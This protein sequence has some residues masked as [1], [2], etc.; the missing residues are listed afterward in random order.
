MER[1]TLM[2]DLSSSAAVKFQPVCVDAMAEI[3]RRAV[4]NDDTAQPFLCAAAAALALYR[5]ALMTAS[6]DPECFS[7]GDVKIT[8]SSTNAAMA[9]EAWRE[10]AAA[11]APYLA[12]DD[13]IFE[14]IQ[15]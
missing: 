12:D 14:R 7:A 2:A 5:W 13:F 4:Q 11:A 8:K 6:V 1:F 10:A 9:K 3:N 15:K